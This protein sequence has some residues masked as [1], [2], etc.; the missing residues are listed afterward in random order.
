MR[1]QYN[2]SIICWSA[3]SEFCPRICSWCADQFCL[4]GVYHFLHFTSPFNL[5]RV[6]ASSGGWVVGA[7]IVVHQYPTAI[8]HKI[9]EGPNQH[10]ICWR[11]SLRP[12]LPSR[13]SWSWASR[14]PCSAGMRMCLTLLLVFGTD[15]ALENLPAACT[16]FE[17]QRFLHVVAESRVRFCGLTSPSIDSFSSP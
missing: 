5:W 1:C 14:L 7:G 9:G 3:W 17:A 16:C 10:T 15:A 11:Q 4:Q 6:V 2:L 13:L 8:L 12:R